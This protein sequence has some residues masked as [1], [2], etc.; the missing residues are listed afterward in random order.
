[1]RPHGWAT[2]QFLDAVIAIESPVRREQLRQEYIAAAHED[3]TEAV[4]RDLWQ[5]RDDYRRGLQGDSS[6]N[7]TETNSD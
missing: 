5:S 2:I 6:G 1:M 4:R 7:G 3:F